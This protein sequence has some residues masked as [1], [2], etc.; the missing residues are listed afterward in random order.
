MDNINKSNNLLSRSNSNS[1]FLDIVVCIINICILGAVYKFI[2]LDKLL[3]V[4]NVFL[5]GF[6]ALTIFTGVVSKINII[7]PLISLTLL[8][9][10]LK[11]SPETTSNNTLPGYSPSIDLN[12]ST[13]STDSFNNVKDELEVLENHG[14][15]KTEVDEIVK[16]LMCGYYPKDDGT[17]EPGY[18][19]DSKNEDNMCCILRKDELSMLEVI[20]EQALGFVVPILIDQFAIPALEKLIK[21]I[22]N[23]KNISPSAIKAALKKNFSTFKKLRQG[24]MIIV[25][26]KIKPTFLKGRKGFKGVKAGK[27]LIKGARSAAK[28]ASASIKLGVKITKTVVR[29]VKAAMMSVTF[30]FEVFSITMDALDPNG[31]SMYIS[32][33]TLLS[34]RNVLLKQAYE[35]HFLIEGNSEENYPP[36]FNIFSD[37]INPILISNK[38]NSNSD[39]LQDIMQYFVLY[40]FKNYYAWIK[41]NYPESVENAEDEFIEKMFKLTE[42]ILKCMDPDGSN[43]DNVGDE[44]KK[45]FE[46]AVVV[47]DGDYDDD[48]YTMYFIVEYIIEPYFEKYLDS[49]ESY[50]RR[51]EF[52]WLY[53]SAILEDDPEEL[54]HYKLWPN[55]SGPISTRMAVSLSEK[56]V[57]R[58]RRYYKNDIYNKIKYQ[59]PDETDDIIQSLPMPLIDNKYFKPKGKTHTVTEDTLTLEKVEIEEMEIKST[60]EGCYLYFGVIPSLWNYCE[61]PRTGKKASVES[62][63]LETS[64]S[65]ATLKPLDYGLRF[66]HKNLTCKFTKKYC[67]NKMQLQFI[68]NPDQC[69]ILPGQDI[70]EMLWGRTVAR[71]LI[72]YGQKVEDSVLGIADKADNFGKCL[73]NLDKDPACIKTTTKE[74]VEEV[75]TNVAE[76][77]GIDLTTPFEERGHDCMR[78]DTPKCTR[79][80]LQDAMDDMKPKTFMDYIPGGDELEQQLGETIAGGFGIGE[81]KHPTFTGGCCN[82]NADLND[83]KSCTYCANGHRGVRPKCTPT[84]VCSGWSPFGVC[85]GE[86]KKIDCKGHDGCTSLRRCN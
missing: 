28:M 52:A 16:D 32:Y 22:K 60:P 2:Y 68:N 61:A 62:A 35:Q 81:R 3:E 57:E 58:L 44:C 40:D 53:L 73:D 21:G 1:S 4:T 63:L 75:V 12:F 72:A 66:D 49:P 55:L 50:I 29:G 78:N 45:R 27:L 80:E 31:Y 43:P 14:L 77:T 30:W 84:E 33:Q 51:D 59:K 65:I 41:E 74:L 36:M 34:M 5:Y 64:T 18:I 42:S 13:E 7:W 25:Q 37:E 76:H 38:Y 83:P 6:I 67:R 9:M 48:E 26:S 47:D 79:E 56:G 71:A 17:C 69:K 19:I 85:V 15:K 70:F 23:A 8:Y 39:I 82:L 24:R 20:Q 54:S 10:S 46:D 86:K 11:K